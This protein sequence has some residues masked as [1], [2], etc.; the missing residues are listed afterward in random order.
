MRDHFHNIGNDRA[1]SRPFLTHMRQKSS[2]PNSDSHSM[3]HRFVGKAIIGQH[4]RISIWL[5]LA[6]RIESNLLRQT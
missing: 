3:R 2:F 6:I 5:M 4:F 1:P